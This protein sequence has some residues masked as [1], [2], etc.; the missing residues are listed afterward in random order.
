MSINR[1]M[2]KEAVVHIYNGILLSHKKRNGIGSFLEMWA[3]LE[4]VIQSEVNWE[5]VVKGTVNNTEL[6]RLTGLSHS[7]P[8]SLII[9]GP[10]TRLLGFAPVPQSPLKLLQLASRK[11]DS[12]PC[13]V[14]STEAT[15]KA[16]AVVTPFL[17]P[18]TST[19]APLCDLPRG[20]GPLLLRSVSVTHCLSNG[21]CL[22]V[23]WF[24][25]HWM[26]VKPI[27]VKPCSWFCQA[28]L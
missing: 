26:V 23:C 8:P 2:D 5:C 25:H 11:P 14:F 1:W 13:L 7:G 16:P 17:L 9:W 22:L 18:L 21:S 19:G 27:Y 15:V 28:L 12:P 24:H 3:D 6:I 4:S 20:R 10:S